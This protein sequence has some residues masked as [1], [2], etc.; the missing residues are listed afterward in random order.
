MKTQKNYFVI[1]SNTGNHTGFNRTWNLI[2]EFSKKKEAV[3]A[4]IE[5]SLY[6]GDL[7]VRNGRAYDR[8]NKEYLC[9]NKSTSF[10]YDGRT[11]TFVERSEVEDFFN[12]GSNGYIPAFIEA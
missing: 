3:Q 1:E 6:V 2:G 8:D 12:G 4:L 9:T 10:N 5:Q 7:D 11:Y